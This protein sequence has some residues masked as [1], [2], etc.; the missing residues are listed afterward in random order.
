MGM[1]ELFGE[2]PEHSVTTLLYHK[3]TYSGENLTSARDRL[4]RELEWLSNN[5]S[6]LTLQGAVKG[7]REGA[8]DKYPL[9]VTADDAFLDL[10]DVYDIFQEFAIP[11]NVYTCAGWTTNSSSYEDEDDIVLLLLDFFQWFAGETELI[12]INERESLCLDENLKDKNIDRILHFYRAGNQEVLESIWDK[13]SGKIVPSKNRNICSWS[14][15]RDLKAQGIAVGSH[16]VTHC[17]LAN[18]SDIRLDFEVRE[19]RQIIKRKL[20]E[21]NS[22]AYPH[23]TPDVWSKRTSDQINRAGYEA[24]FLTVPGFAAYGSEVFC[25]PRIIIP[26]KILSFEEYRAHVKGGTIPIQI[27]KDF[28]NSYRKQGATDSEYS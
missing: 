23:G 8:L 14:E 3:F 7:L 10:L 4:K 15:L 1:P 28:I 21:C 22:F 18:K 24:A 19:S 13:I 12:K 6:P 27:V 5:Y 25:L 26:N 20:G 16:T 2:S 11:L 9:V 17:R